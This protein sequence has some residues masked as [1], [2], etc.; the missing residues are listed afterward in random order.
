VALCEYLIRT[1][2]NPGEVVLDSFAGSGTTLV[3]AR[4]TGRRFIGLGRDE[5]YFRA[6]EARIWPALPAEST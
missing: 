4:N 1:Y 6:A 2:R 3:A 5:E